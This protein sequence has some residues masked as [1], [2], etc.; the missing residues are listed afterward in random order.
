VAIVREG[1]RAAFD[2]AKQKEEVLAERVEE[3]GKKLLDVQSR[4]ASVTVLQREVETNRQLYDA[5]LQR[6]KDVGITASVDANNISM[7]DPA[8]VPDAPYWPNV[9]RW[10]L[11]AA[12][13]GLFIGVALALLFESLDDTLKRPEELERK[14]GV[15]V[16]GVIPKL[17]GIT[18]DEAL[19][20]TR[21]AFSEAYRSV[22]TSLQFSSENGVPRCLLVTSSGSGEGKST[23]AL[24]LARNLAQLGKRVLLIDADLRNPSLHRALG[25]ENSVGLSN[26]LA[27]GI[28][29]AAAI[30]PTK[31]LRL[32]FI[33]SGP[34]P[35]N[36]AELLS[37]PKLVSLLSLASEKFDQ[38]II[39][40]PPVMGL[41]DALILSN[42]A[43][44]TVLVVESGVTRVA[45][46]KATLKRLVTARSHLLGA[47]LTKFDAKVAGYGYGYGSDY[48]SYHYYS[49]GGGDPKARLTHG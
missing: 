17:D 33:P 28:K 22:R 30:R 21:S 29:P 37:G 1:L 8:V 14:L 38:V 41:A 45:M 10:T 36:P 6:F 16:L 35:P 34:L 31:Q 27:G 43:S 24:T 42:L 40:G 3:V 25:C 7:V 49:Y 15:A 2:G 26:Y 9:P 48:S 12:L 20:D 46:A 11:F 32:T 44:G 4:R 19:E 13:L 5:L 39:D 18:V 23:T 47:V